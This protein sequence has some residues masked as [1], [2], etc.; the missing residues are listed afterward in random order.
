[1]KA[2]N[3]I[4]SVAAFFV[5]SPLL[6]IVAGMLVRFG[7]NGYVGLAVGATCCYLGGRAL[8]RAM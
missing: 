5:G 8:L 1:M 6:F 7:V 4:P 2:K 3:E